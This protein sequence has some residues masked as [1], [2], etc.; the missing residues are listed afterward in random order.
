MKNTSFIFSLIKR[1]IG[2][3]FLFLNYLCYGLMISLAANQ[4]LSPFERVLYPILV[5]A[6]SWVFVILGVYLA[7]PD[8]IA[9]IKDIYTS[10]KSKFTRR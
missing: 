4:D 7:G 2:I 6:V 3:F 8:K 9:K 5:Y 1:C 10:I